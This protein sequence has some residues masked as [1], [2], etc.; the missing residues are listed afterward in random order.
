MAA[1][2]AGEIGDTI[3]WGTG[4]FIKKSLLPSL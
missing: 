4:D 1:L 3:L 2:F